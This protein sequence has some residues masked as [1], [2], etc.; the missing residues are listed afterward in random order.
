MSPFL[1]G[2]LWSA[3]QPDD[4]V[5]IP[6]NCGWCGDGT[7]PMGVGLALQAAQRYPNLPAEYGAYCRD[8]VAKTGGHCPPAYFDAY[9][10]VLVPTKPLNVRHPHLSWQNKA[11]PDL[12]REGLRLLCEQP[13]ARR[14]RLLVPLLG[15]GAGG[16]SRGESIALC[17][18]LPQ[19]ST[20]TVLF[21][22]AEGPGIIPKFRDVYAYLSNFYLVPVEYEGVIYPSSEH[23]F[24][25]AKT[26]DPKIREWIRSSDTPGEAKKRGRTVRLHRPDWD[27]ISV[28]V[29]RQVVADKFRRT[30][31]L[32]MKL[33]STGEDVLVE[34]NNWGDH[35]FGVDGWGENNLGRVLMDVRAELRGGAL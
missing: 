7:N 30:Y 3:R 9:K 32:T 16:L 24:Q 10:L 20:N 2:D 35:R 5:C 34:G 18:P 11:S 14:G 26:Q 19:H 4:W 31:A 1:Y 6:T 25:A 15:A 27:A 21:H 8:A 22:P 28:G 23:A 33:L 12:I 17:A 29:M 13:H